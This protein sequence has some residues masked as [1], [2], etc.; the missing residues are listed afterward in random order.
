MAVPRRNPK[1]IIEPASSSTA[2]KSLERPGIYVI[3][4]NVR[5]WRSFYITIIGHRRK[6]FFGL[7]IR[8]GFVSVHQS[9]GLGNVPPRPAVLLLTIRVVSGTVFLCDNW[10]HY[11]SIDNNTFNLAYTQDSSGG[12]ETTDVLN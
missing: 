9:V 12:S 2:S 1:L 5:W 11:S 6:L 4:C 10:L 8:L 3:C 7:I